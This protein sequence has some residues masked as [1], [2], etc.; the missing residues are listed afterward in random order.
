MGA[1]VTAPTLIG[2][3]LDEVIDHLT[4]VELEQHLDD[5]VPC[6]VGANDGCDQP[7]HWAVRCPTCGLDWT[8]CDPHRIDKDARVEWEG[9]TGVICAGEGVGCHSV[10]PVPLNWRP[11]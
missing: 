4:I 6:L 9:D 3:V 7:A 5:D 11:L 10:M 8:A 1:V 2:P